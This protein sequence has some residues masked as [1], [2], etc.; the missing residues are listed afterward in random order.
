MIKII[1]LSKYSFIREKINIILNFTIILY[2]FVIPFQYYITK[3]VVEILIILWV[4]SFN[5]L[6]VIN[7]LRVNRIFQT[8]IALSVLIFL[9]YFWSGDYPNTVYGDIKVFFKSYGYFFLFPIIIITSS[10]KAKYISFVIYSFL[11]SMFV[12]EIISYGIFFE[13][14]TTP[15]GTPFN[16][17]PFQISHITYSVFVAF[18]ILLS[19]YKIKQ[20]KNKLLKLIF[21][22][23][24]IT[25]SINLFMS[26]GRT[27]QIA[28]LLTLFVL[29]L[30]YFRQDLKKIFFLFFS[31]ITIF[32]FAYFSVNTFNVRIN[33]AIKDISML[34]NSEKIQ[35][36]S[37]GDR[38]MAF[39]ATM[40]IIEP[41]NLLFGVGM[42]DKEE[43]V[44][45]RLQEEDYPHKLDNFLEY[46][47]L[48]NMYLEMLI[49]NGIIGLLLLLFLF[50]SV[51]KV[52]ILDN[53][54]KYISYVTGLVFMF[55][56][57]PGDI[58]FFYEMMLLFGL[59]LSLIIVQY[60]FEQETLKK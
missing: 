25:M 44:K 13:F 47:R 48:H 49:S 58:F 3:Q 46:G 59:F 19:F 35:T 17:V 26:A 24:F 34:I 5:Y 21:I 2:A 43:Y 27:G 8:I 52:N 51:L 55:V 38:L 42:G 54:L 31:T 9:S 23:F 7:L 28:L 36:S 56:A 11:A 40:Y 12:N 16:P 39:N 45:K 37:L 15:S 29:I 41:K 32:I 18:S 4:L 60:N 10:L 53:H 6:A 1:D 14:W 57:L 22:F 50:Y 33:T 30:I 20:I